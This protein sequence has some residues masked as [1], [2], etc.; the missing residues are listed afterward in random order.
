VRLEVLRPEDAVCLEII[1]KTTGVSNPIIERLVPSLSP[2]N[3]VTA[4]A[5][6][7]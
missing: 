6:A 1:P 5:S 2:Q 3:L 4:A 7:D